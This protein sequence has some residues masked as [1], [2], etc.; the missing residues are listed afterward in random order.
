MVENKKVLRMQLE[1]EGYVFC[2]R[3]KCDVPKCTSIFKWGVV[4]EVDGICVTMTPLNINF[5]VV[6]LLSGI[7]LN[8]TRP[9]TGAVVNLLVNCLY[10][11]QN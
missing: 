2:I 1:D 11:D 6:L 8:Y 3:I 10:V 9:E 4:Q 5:V 7:A